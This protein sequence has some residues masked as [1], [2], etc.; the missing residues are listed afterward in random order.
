MSSPPPISASSDL[1]V[2]SS[3]SYASGMCDLDERGLFLPPFL[4]TMRGQENN[5]FPVSPG[6]I[7]SSGLPNHY[8]DVTYVYAAADNGT[9]PKGGGG[10]HNR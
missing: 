2:Y 10:G 8:S 1:V 4:S 3:H 5:T 6:N 9:T 7:S